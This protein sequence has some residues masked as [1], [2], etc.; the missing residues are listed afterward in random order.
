MFYT[1][2]KSIIVKKGFLPPPSFHEAKVRAFDD[3]YIYEVISNGV[4]NMPDYKKQIPTNDR[5]AIVAYVRALQRTQNA[6]V[7]DVPE[8]KL[9]ELN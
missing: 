7:N 4:R 8:D 3:G 6:S 1:H 9:N 2:G 5:W